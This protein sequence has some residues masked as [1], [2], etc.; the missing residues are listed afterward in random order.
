[1][2][3]EKVSL[4]DLSFDLNEDQWS[5]IVLTIRDYLSLDSFDAW[6]FDPSLDMLCS[7]FEVVP[8]IRS[9]LLSSVEGFADI[10]DFDEVSQTGQSWT[11]EILLHK[12]PAFGAAEA[13]LLH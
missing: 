4:I 11:H 12:L 13:G 6:I 8:A 10:L 7:L 3:V 9:P 1:M 5:Q 2:S